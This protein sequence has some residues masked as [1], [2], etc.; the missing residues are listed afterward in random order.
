LLASA[1]KTRLAVLH[2]HALTDS[3]AVYNGHGV[4][5]ARAQR[6]EAVAAAEAV[7]APLPLAADEPLH[8]EDA[9]AEDVDE[10]DGEAAPEALTVTEAEAA[11]LELAPELAVDSSDTLA[12]PVEVCEGEAPGWQSLPQW[13]WACPLRWGRR[14]W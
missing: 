4:L 6:T 3:L 14:R 10:G 5:Q 11:P 7:A 8:S 2:C 1:S 12:E 9:L 13:P